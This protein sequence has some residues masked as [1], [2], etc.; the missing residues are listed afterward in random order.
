[1]DADFPPSITLNTNMMDEENI[2]AGVSASRSPH[3]PHKLTISTL[4]IRCPSQ[5]RENID[6]NV[7]AIN[8]IPSIIPSVK[9]NIPQTN[10]IPI[11]AISMDLPIK[12]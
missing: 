9:G 7:Q 10:Y 5:I 3:G 2:I 12:E 11:K 1:M 6:T 4:E 8:N